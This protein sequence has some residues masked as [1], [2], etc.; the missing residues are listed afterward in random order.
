MMKAFWD[1]L[2]EAHALSVQLKKTLTTKLATIALQGTVHPGALR[3]WKEK[4]VKIVKPLVYTDADVAA[5]KAKVAA[6]K[7][8]AKMKK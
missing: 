7:A 5:F 4:G 6:R 3:Y 8:K 2:D 1:H